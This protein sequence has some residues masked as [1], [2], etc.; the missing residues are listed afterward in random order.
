MKE[1]STDPNFVF[2]INTGTHNGNFPIHTHSY[3][4]LMIVLEGSSIHEVGT[5]KYELK[6]DDVFLIS[7]HGFKNADNFRLFNI[8]FDLKNFTEEFDWLKRLSGFQSLF[9]IEPFYRNELRFE[10]RFRLNLHQLEFVKELLNNMLLEYEN[11]NNSFQHIINTYFISLTS[12]ISRQFSIS[13]NTSTKKLLH[14]ADTVSCIERNFTQ[15]FTLETLASTTHLSVRHF[16][17][18]F[19]QIY[20]LTPT[21]YIIKLRI[22]QSCR[23]LTYTN[24]SVTQIAMDCGFYDSASYSKQFKQRI[25]ISPTKYRNRILS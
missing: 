20:N 1:F 3:S 17:R 23:Y 2:S 25:G 16:T 19:K 10:S 22:E 15:S 9:F 24:L 14:F 11:K 12:Y 21:E 18:I 8:M 6:A 13:E 7:R 4:E 5:L